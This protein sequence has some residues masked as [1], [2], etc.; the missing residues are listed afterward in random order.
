MDSPAQQSTSVSYGEI[1]SMAEYKYY[2][3]IATY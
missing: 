2:Y 1:F 3:D